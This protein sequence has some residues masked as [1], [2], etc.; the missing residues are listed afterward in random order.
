MHFQFAVQEMPNWRAQY[1]RLPQR[2][3]RRTGGDR[4][5]QPQRV[6]LILEIKDE[7]FPGRKRLDGRL[8]YRRRMGLGLS[9]GERLSPRIRDFLDT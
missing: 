4:G 2:R 7:L 8:H 9:G 1:D 3:N 5:W 6:P